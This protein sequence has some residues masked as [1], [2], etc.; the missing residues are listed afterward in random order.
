MDIYLKQKEK[1]VVYDKLNVTV[2]DLC[3]VISDDKRIEDL[4]VYK[5]NE[6]EYKRYVITSIDI[7]RR[8]LQYNK[9]LCVNISGINDTVVEYK[10]KKNDGILQKIKVLVVGVV[11]FAGASTT[12]MSFHN[13]TAIPDVFNQ[14]YKLFF[15]TGNYSELFITIPYSLGIAL[16]I[17][18]FFNHIF[19]KS[20]TDSP[21]PIEVEIVKYES[22]IAKAES[23]M[24]EHR[25]REDKENG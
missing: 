22:D 24:E 11:V 20:L 19:G 2:G 1:I 17:I 13:E 21:T 15:G 3:D 8:I 10:K 12:I 7:T 4:V 5:I 25:L 18:L 14:Y 23:K 9:T 16:G 6:S